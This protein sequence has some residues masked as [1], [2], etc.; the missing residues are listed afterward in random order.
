MIKH[1][2]LRRLN[3]MLSPP[4]VLFSKI[5]DVSQPSQKAA[6]YSST[7][8]LFFG[9]LPKSSLVFIALPSRRSFH[10]ASIVTSYSIRR[11]SQADHPFY[12]SSCSFESSKSKCILL[13]TKKASQLIPHTY[14]MAEWV[15]LRWHYRRNVTL[16]TTLLLLIGF[17]TIILS[18]WYLSI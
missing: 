18:S 14:P 9:H 6:I 2:T 17:M 7:C 12:S 5:R 15:A 16:A 10:A 1:H 3:S 11:T 13:T 4:A 8:L